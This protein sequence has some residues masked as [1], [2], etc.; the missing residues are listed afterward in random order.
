MLLGVTNLR[1]ISF[2]C[3]KMKQI[4]FLSNVILNYPSLPIGR[5]AIVLSD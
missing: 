1:S 5:H 2:S 3:G 4:V